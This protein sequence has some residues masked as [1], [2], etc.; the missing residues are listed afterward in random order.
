MAARQLG[1][2]P[3]KLAELLLDLELEGLVL[4]EGSRLTLGPRA[5]DTTPAG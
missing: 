5:R 4:R 1:I 3:S 2:Q